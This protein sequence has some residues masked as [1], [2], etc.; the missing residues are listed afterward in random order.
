[1]EEAESIHNLQQRLH[2]LEQ[3]NAELH[4]QIHDL[5][6]RMN[7]F[8]IVVR[9]TDNSVMIYN[10]HLKLEWVN[11]SFRKLFACSMSR[12][13]ELY[14]ESIL[15]NSI[16]ENIK[17]IIDNC[18]FT[19]NSAIYETY[20]LDSQGNRQWVHRNITPIFGLDGLFD[21]LVVIDFN[22]TPQKMA[23]E[24]INEQKQALEHQHELA[25]QQRDEIQ[26]QKKEI[27]QAFKKNSAQS[28]K[29]QSLLEKL[30]EQNAE[31]EKARQ[32]AD[33]AN[34][35]KS[36]FL[37]NMSHEIR[38][39]MN[40][41]IGMTQLLLKTNLSPQQRD[42]AKTVQDSAESLLTIINDI[43]DISKIEAGK[44]ELDYHE[45]NFKNLMQ[46]IY[47]LLEVKFSEKSVQFI[48]DIGDDVSEYINGDSTR[49]KQVLI[50]LVNNALKFTE[51]GSVTLHVKTLYKD[52]ENTRI[53]FGVEDTGIGIPQD[54]LASVFEKFTQADTSTTRK[55]GGTGLGLSISVQLIE[56]M[57]GKLE[58]SSTVDVGST[59]FFD[60]PF[61]RV[62]EE[63][64]AEIKRKEDMESR[65]D[66]IS[67]APGLRILVAED[68]LTNQKY[69][70]NL[71]SM[72]NLE[73]E[74]V[75]NGKLAY[76]AVQ[77]KEFDCVLMDM[78]MPEMNGVDATKAIRELQDATKSNIP[79]IALTA[80]AYKEDED[81]MMGAGVNAFLTKPVNEPKLLRTLQAIDEKFTCVKVDVPMQ[82]PV[83]EPQIS[84]TVTEV[85]VVQENCIHVENVQNQQ[86]TIA[87]D[88]SGPLITQAD[89][90]ENFGMFKADV[91]NDIIDDFVNNVEAKMARIKSRIDADEMR[92]L[93]LDAHSL[94]GE[95]AMFAAYKA[96]EAMFTLE[97][98][99]RKEIRDN[100]QNDYTTAY[101]L[102]MQLKNELL[103]YK[104]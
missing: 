33:K 47:K 10:K 48:I 42:Y 39:P 15:T 14:G 28:V 16:E 85:S 22:I 83:A 64:K 74:I 52:T 75:D 26:L 51:Q 11:V 84:A 5:Q 61:K 25:I 7:R 32:I 89:F 19:K 50:N 46:S 6:T 66:A 67:F 101:T 1:M 18:I 4:A 17:S 97:D 2:Q 104:K 31:L 21:K 34:E 63:R 36:Q 54:K 90:Y 65:V 62:S 88:E 73:V 100:L 68:N 3:L 80:A 60:L 93:M 37:A 102:V 43:L 29:M 58:V 98:K 53:Y 99:G 57:G 103:G 35:D 91:L 24:A 59:F 96:K 82:E 13:I 78:H 9:Q 49:L 76:E 72:Y 30:N 56:M 71:L 38:T 27:E 40:G 45:F 77:A 41:V 70:R 8:K 95:V 79:I 87:D 55:Y 12:F 69:I 86:E 20:I 92:K 23:Q 81:R 44:I 94:K